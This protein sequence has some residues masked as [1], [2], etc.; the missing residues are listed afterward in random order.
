MLSWSRRCPYAIIMITQNV[1]I[2]FIFLNQGSSGRLNTICL[3]FDAAPGKKYVAE[4][5][6]VTGWG[7]TEVDSKGVRSDI[8]LLNVE[9]DCNLNWNTFAYVILKLSLKTFYST[10]FQR[11]ISGS[12]ADT[13]QKVDVPVMDTDQC[14]RALNTTYRTEQVNK[15][16]NLCAGGEQG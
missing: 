10:R 5:L 1:T 6:T 14:A 8:L 16:K 12:Q 11:A 9:L 3:P 7:Y 2:S 13:L 15:G 4:T